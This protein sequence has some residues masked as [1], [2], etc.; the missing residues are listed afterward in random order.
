MKKI[1]YSAIITAFF[2]TACK[3]DPECTTSTS[4]LSAAYKITSVRYQMTP[5]LAE[6]DYFNLLFPD[7]CDR[8]NLY[9][10]KENGSYTITDA[11]TICSPSGDDSGTW[12]LTGTT[13][14]VDGDPVAIESFDCKTLVLV[15][16]DTQVAG[17]KLK[18]ILTKQ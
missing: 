18:L 13:M 10:F 3:K 4:T 7:P 6:S 5:A 17:D 9:T 8:D 11:G 2:V 14:T 1:I 15:N 16:T 12:S